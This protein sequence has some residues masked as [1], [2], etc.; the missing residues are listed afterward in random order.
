M[1]DVRMDLA[2]VAKF[3]DSDLSIGIINDLLDSAPVMAALS[4][5]SIAGHTYN[6]LK[7]TSATGL[8]GFRDENSGREENKAG[9]TKVTT[10]LKILDASF[11]V[12]VAVADADERGVAAMLSTQAVDHLRAA[13]YA[14]EDNLINGTG[15]NGFDGLADH[16]AALGDMVIDGGATTNCSSVYAVRTGVNA[17]SSV[18]GASGVINIGDTSIQR[19]A[20]ASGSFSAYYTPVVAWAG[21]QVGGKYDAARLANVSSLNDDKISDL[22]SLFP[23]GGMPDYL[24]MNRVQLK[25]LQQSRTAT[26]PSGNPAP[27]PQECFGV[28]VIVSDAIGNAESVVS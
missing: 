9:Y 3:N 22:L 26:N 6:Y 23:A 1:A 24:I 18:W 28:P 14:A 13:F 16:L 7:K 21:L 11:S 8:A 2:E 19:I 27:F 17:V 25:A 20:D 10:N 4:A 12:D 5:K 15:T